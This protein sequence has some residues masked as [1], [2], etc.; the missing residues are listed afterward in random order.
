M[1]KQPLVVILSGTE[2]ERSVVEEFDCNSC[3]D[4]E[5]TYQLM[6]TRKEIL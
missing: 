3:S 5:N 2:R 6:P 4:F 1:E